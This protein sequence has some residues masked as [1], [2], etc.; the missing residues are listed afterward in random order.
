MSDAAT[1][2]RI[3]EYNLETAELTAAGKREIALRLIEAGVT[4]PDTELARKIFDTLDRASVAQDPKTPITVSAPLNFQII[5]SE[6][7][8]QIAPPRRKRTLQVGAATPVE[9]AV[10]VLPADLT[11][12]E[13]EPVALPAVF[14]EEPSLSDFLPDE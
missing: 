11:M 10:E 3:R 7:A 8:E 14:D 6:D 13:M 9:D 12:V 5:M 2:A 1:I 4:T